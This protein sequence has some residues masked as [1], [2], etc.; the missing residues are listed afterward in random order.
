MGEGK[1]GKKEG[2]EAMVVAE[3]NLLVYT[4]IGGTVPFYLFIPFNCV[5]VA[6][7]AFLALFRPSFPVSASGCLACV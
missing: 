4:S 7:T 2:S 5:I 1:E 3:G 6:P